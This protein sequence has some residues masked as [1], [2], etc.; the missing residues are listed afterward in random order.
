MPAR[1]RQANTRAAAQPQEEE[2]PYNI[3]NLEFNEA[4]SWR[5]GR[6]IPVADLLTRLQKL[7]TELRNAEQGSVDV[8]DIAKLAHDL[9]NPNLLGHKDKGIRAWTVSCVVDILN[10]TAPNAPYSNPQLR[11]IFTVIVNTI[12][13]ALADPSNAYNAQH[14]YILD[15]LVDTQS[16][17]LIADIQ[18]NERLLSQL[19][20]VC[21][22]V[23]A[24]SGRNASGVDLA[25]SVVF[26]IGVALNTVVDEANLPQDVIDIV[27]SQF[28]RVDP[29]S[30]QQEQPKKK[31]T[32]DPKDKSQSTL[33]LK[34]YPPAYHLAKNVCTTSSEK[35]SAAI[36][37]YFGS[38]IANASAAVAVD[39]DAKAKSL[40]RPLAHDSDSEDDNQETLNDLRKVH[41]LV[42]ELWRACPDVLNNV[43]PQLELELAADSATLRQLAVETLGDLVAGI[44]LA[45]LPE[46]PPLDPAAFPLPTIEHDS[47]VSWS[48]NPLLTPSS[49]KPFI[50][51]HPHA[52]Q[53][54]LGRRVDKA[55]PVRTAWAA[56]AS[57]VLLT[58]A[59]GIGLDEQEQNVLV[60]GYAHILKDVDDKVRLTALQS[61]ESFPYWSVVEV[62]GSDGGLSQ[63]TSLLST[64]AERVTDRKRDVREQA[65][66]LLGNMWGVASRDIANH[67]DRVLTVLGQAPTKLLSAMFVKD[68]HITAWVSRVLYEC[69][70]PLTY[71]PTKSKSLENSKTE[72]GVSDDPDSVRVRRLLALV[73]EL[74]EKAK[75]V[76]FGIQKRQAEMSKAIGM[77]LQACENYNGGV[78]DDSA[79]EKRLEGQL[80]RFIESLSRQMPDAS[81]TSSDLWKFAKTHD[82][83][84]YQLI[85]FMTG[86]DHDF[87]TVTKAMKEF[88]KRL[89]SDGMI[90]VLETLT[91]IL[92][93]CALISYNRSHIPAIMAYAKS[94][95]SA[96]AEVAQEVLKEISEKVPEVMKTHIQVL[97]QEL[98]EAAPSEN[99]TESLTAVDSL[100]ACAAF[101]KRFP[102][103]V[104]KDRKF[105]VSMMNFVLYS[106]SPKAAKHAANIVLSAS[107]KQDFHAKEILTKAIKR[108]DSGAKNKLAQ[109][110][111]IAQ[112][113]LHSPT[114]ANDEDD[115]I[116]N[117]AI[118][119]TLL[120]NESPR[121]E[122]HDP[123]A[124]DED[125]DEETAAKQLALKI[126][127]NR[128][129][130]GD[131][132]TRESFD[133][134]ASSVM[135]VLVE[136]VRKDGEYA[137]TEDT[138]SAQRNRLRLTAGR[139]LLKL[140]RYKPRCEELVT[141]KMFMDVAWMFMSRPFA[142]RRGLVQSLKKYL[143]TNKLNAR[144]TTALFLTAFEPDTATFISIVAWL[145]SRTAFY[146]R[147]QKQA[148]P[149]GDKKVAVQN[150]VEI[151]F[152]RLLSLLVYY[153]DYPSKEDPSY[154]ADVL[155]LSHFLL[156]Y[157]QSCANEDN[158]SLIFHI[159]QRI[160][161][162]ADV[163]SKSDK[164]DERL[165]ILSDLAQ[166]TIRNFADQMAGGAK[167]VN[168][169]Q[170]WPGKAH[171]PA[172]LFKPI[173]GHAKAQ[174]IASKNYLPEE[175]AERL[176]PT[177]RKWV[178]IVRHG[179]NPNAKKTVSTG[180]DKK[181]KSS[182][183]VDLDDDDDVDVAK[184]SVKKSKTRKANTALATRKT[185]NPK[186]RKSEA[187]TS[188]EQ[189]SRKS[190]RTSTVKKVNYEESDEDE[191][192]AD[193]TQNVV[194][195]NPAPIDK[196]KHKS[197]KAA[198]P[199]I[200]EEDEE[201]EIVDEEQD[202]AGSPTPHGK[203]AESEGELEA[204]D[205]HDI[206]EP[207]EPQDA[208][209]TNGH[210]EAINAAEEEH[211]QMVPADAA[212]EEE[213]DDAAE[214]GEGEE[215]E[216]EPEPKPSPPRNKK[217]SK[218]KSAVPP[219]A[220][221][222]KAPKP[223]AR[224]A[225]ETKKTQA[226]SPA[227]KKVFVQTSSP[228]SEPARR[229]T[230]RTRA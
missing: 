47:L 27:I 61:L 117:I 68:V 111:A 62:L 191:E 162:A 1:S 177:V 146:A 80:G 204:E 107:N 58:R 179:G 226:K 184:K 71:P 168:L 70:L 53:A 25:Q 73:L 22:D 78:A 142:V 17:V 54:W 137:P 156:L 4:L 29:R 207:E 40:R 175:V 43:I 206:V 188:A 76:F 26:Q 118:T 113:C 89:T 82:R 209:M 45:G 174:E 75:M 16:I 228:A 66:L 134:L 3:P 139:S 9:V 132:N 35:M 44:G 218:G 48:T 91:P 30:N 96:F 192:D 11:D 143:V 211:E 41:R 194:K 24:G 77:F 183:S 8:K 106:T 7:S 163:V 223:K 60:S 32:T 167:G 150:V 166:A 74:D 149:S 165:Y 127:V 189:P 56:T 93:Q 148:R 97:C 19:F 100:K 157:L 169:L 160:K 128:C 135:D 201:D 158:L 195:Y 87:R 112:V 227:Q 203:A 178:K 86:A 212:V 55:V 83:R 95:D 120:K 84:S 2:G 230:R 130:S 202:E 222:S 42:R 217:A 126:L 190:V 116:L 138:P 10:L 18:D 101:A 12:L 50:H 216:P 65:M 63:P 20:S 104:P 154:D 37:N 225:K 23:V 164:M 171:L 121:T 39:D 224:A 64:V 210:N 229:S 219:K 205:D 182:V 140:C 123:N 152:A 172:S 51:V 81:R 155:D 170:T 90:T 141:P 221:K 72:L 185:P 124:W 38:I 197:K 214:D 196:Y 114:A 187:V 213:E 34:D 145:R 176:E 98:Q 92:Y 59:G 94:A 198:T 46:L 28:L 125:L 208:E 186:K 199:E 31:R 122:A 49:P 136:V 57:R 220:T 115:Q 102:D 131:E 15:Q 79:E 105:V 159:A 103:E 69:L 193:D 151:Q 99:G 180:L 153:P 88:N 133:T 6:A 144:W 52:Y 5:A 173:N 108:H 129:R 13:P 200:E 14:Q 181:R 119:S 110:A 67:H 85:R 147:Q 161:Q 33:L 21:F 36:G 215:E 109:L